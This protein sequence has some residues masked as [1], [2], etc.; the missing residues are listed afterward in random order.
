VNRSPLTGKRGFSLIEAL[1]ALSI[2]AISLTAILE[3]QQQ[4]ARGQEHAEAA[5]RRVTLRQNMLVAVSNLNPMAQPEGDMQLP[6]NLTLHWTSEPIS[7]E[8]LNSGF[9]SG[10]GLFRVRLYRVT[11]TAAGADH[12]Q[13]ATL[14]VERLGWVSLRTGPSAF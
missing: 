3:L 6:P 9:P 12:S 13:L 5:M 4:L 7:P 2:A 1:V 8:K 11:I 10:E 14:S